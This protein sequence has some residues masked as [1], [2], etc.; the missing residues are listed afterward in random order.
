MKKSLNAYSIGGAIAGFLNTAHGITE[1][2]DEYVAHVCD[3]AEL[4]L[5]DEKDALI[6]LLKSEIAYSSFAID[7]LEMVY[8]F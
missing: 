8:A 1:S 2:T 7:L 3:Y 6:M 5:A 4:L